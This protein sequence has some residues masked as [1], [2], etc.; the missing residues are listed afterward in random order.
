MYYVYS[1]YDS[2]CSN[3]SHQDFEECNT[4]EAALTYVKE[5]EEDDYVVTLIEGNEVYY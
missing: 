4:L 5:M 2:R 1:Y 3:E